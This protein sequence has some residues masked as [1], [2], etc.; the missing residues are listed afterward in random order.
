MGETGEGDRGRV[1]FL[2]PE[3][4]DAAGAPVPTPTHT[5]WDDFHKLCE[6]LM[7]AITARIRGSLLADSTTID[8]VNTSLVGSDYLLGRK[9]S[10]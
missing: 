6:T 1:S 5:C 2:P 7:S 9:K 10:F 4:K 3:G 8:P